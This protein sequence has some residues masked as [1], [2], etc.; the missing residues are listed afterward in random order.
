MAAA[1]SALAGGLGLTLD[2]DAC[3]GAT[4]LEDDVALFSES[5]GRFLVTIAPERATELETLFDG[6]AC[7]QVGEVLADPRLEVRRGEVSVLEVTIEELRASFQG[8]LDRE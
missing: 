8:G 1:R 4:D 3:P 5:N 6:L 2:L 7:R